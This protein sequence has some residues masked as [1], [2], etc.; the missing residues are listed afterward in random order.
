MCVPLGHRNG[1]R[2]SD[3]FFPV[4]KIKKA[5]ADKV[6]DNGGFQCFCIKDGKS[7]VEPCEVS[8]ED[9]H[10]ILHNGT[11][12][13]KY[14]GSRTRGYEAGYDTLVMTAPSLNATILLRRPR[15]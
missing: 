9:L 5:D 2:S 15:R 7:E 4:E 3:W 13:V 8:N 11:T 10:K 14:A 1:S 6:I 12:R